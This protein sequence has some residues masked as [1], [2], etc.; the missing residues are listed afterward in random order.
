MSLALSPVV[1]GQSYLWEERG[2][3]S[4]KNTTVLATLQR[5]ST[6]DSLE[7]A[8]SDPAQMSQVAM[9]TAHKLF[10]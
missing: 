2:L 10:P 9:A 6:P 4:R 7:R 5:P 3:H 1:L 8:P